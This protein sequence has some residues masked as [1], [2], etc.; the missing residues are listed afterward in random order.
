[1]KETLNAPT[2]NTV[3]MAEQIDEIYN[4][5][6]LL[7]TFLG[8]LSPGIEKISKETNTNVRELREKF[9]VDETVVLLKKMG[10]N[11]PT[12]IELLDTMKAVKGMMEDFAPA[13]EKITKEVMPNVA[14]LRTSLEKDEV[15]L[16]L[17]KTGE[18]INTFNKLLDVLTELQKS[19]NLDSLLRMIKIGEKISSSLSDEEIDNLGDNL[20]TLLRL[21][22]KVSK[23]EVVKFAEGLL[24]TVSSVD[25]KEPK[26]VGMLGLMSALKDSEVQKSLGITMDLAKKLPKNLK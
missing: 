25:V 26:K 23:P 11:I 22:D 16:L 14:M 20:V 9:E 13:S 6:I 4:K 15:L 7:E 12:F 3:R 1:V 10:D 2:N 5:L 24:D 21:S 17:Q 18:N 19:G 8:D